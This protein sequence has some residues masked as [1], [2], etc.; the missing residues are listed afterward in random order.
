MRIPGA[1]PPVVVQTRQL[2]RARGRRAAFA[3]VAF[4]FPDARAGA[5]AVETA[6]PAAVR[7]GVSLYLEAFAV[8]TTASGLMRRPA[9]RS[10]RRRCTARR[11]RS[12]CVTAPLVDAALSHF[13]S[14]SAMRTDFGVK[15]VWGIE[16]LC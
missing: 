4:P 6:A 14:S 9:P 15:L 2:K 5:L 7:G 16:S 11:M 10:L 8:A 3:G 12:F 13:A 1:S